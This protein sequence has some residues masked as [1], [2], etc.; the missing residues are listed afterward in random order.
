MKVRN[1]KPSSLLVFF[2][3]LACG[4]ISTKTYNTESRLLQERK[5]YC[6]QACPCIF[7]TG[8]LQ[9]GAV[10]GLMKHDVVTVTV[11]L[12]YEYSV[13]C[14]AYYYSIHL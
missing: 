14:R 12:I 3:A 8:N 1:L 11:R 2:F 5:I 4:R 6:L 9:A 10:K 7:Q 13:L